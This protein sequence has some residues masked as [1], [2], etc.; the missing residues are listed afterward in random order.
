MNPKAINY[1]G[2]FAHVT[3][4]S[5]CWIREGLFSGIF[6]YIYIYPLINYPFLKEKTTMQ[7]FAKK[8]GWTALALANLWAFR[9]ITKS[10]HRYRLTSP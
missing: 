4:F 2:K 3:A 8:I 1:L 6:E 7:E 10:I 9:W 5:V